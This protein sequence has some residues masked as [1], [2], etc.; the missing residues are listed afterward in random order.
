[1]APQ[2]QQ[3]SGGGRVLASTSQPSLLAR[4]ADPAPP[5]DGGLD[6]GVFVSTGPPAANPMW[7]GGS[8]WGG[9]VWSGSS[10]PTFPGPTAA[11]PVSHWENDG[12][13]TG[14]RREGVDGCCLGGRLFHTMKNLPLEFLTDCSSPSLEASKPTPASQYEPVKCDVFMGH[15]HKSESNHA[16]PSGSACGAAP[17]VTVALWVRI[18]VDLSTDGSDV[19]FHF[20]PRFNEKVIV[21]NSFIDQRWG[22]EERKLD[23]F[24]FIPGQPFE[25]RHCLPDCCVSA[26]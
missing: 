25:V 22:R 16:G 6:S 7:P 18:T 3:P 15:K 20:N 23:H 1:M 2:H 10:G 13:G 9:P 14:G 17:S 8:A 24:P 4:Y 12:G 19:A 11:Q 21:R 26:G 5:T